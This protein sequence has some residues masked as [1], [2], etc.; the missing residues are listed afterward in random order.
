LTTGKPAQTLAAL[1]SDVYAISSMAWSAD[2]RLAFASSDEI[3]RIP[4][5]D[6]TGISPCNWLLRNMNANEWKGVPGPFSYRYNE[7]CPNLPK[8]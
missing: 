4:R 3:I 5:S 2:G 7:I 1:T 6:L 8:P